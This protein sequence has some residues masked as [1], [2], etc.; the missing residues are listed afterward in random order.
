MNFS[1]ECK[2]MLVHN[3]VHLQEIPPDTFTATKKNFEWKTQ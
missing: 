1:H 2:I 3:S